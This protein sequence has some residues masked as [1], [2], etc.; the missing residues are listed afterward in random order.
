MLNGKVDW[1][2]PS[3]A[4][5]P[6]A[7]RARQKTRDRALL[8]RVEGA[9]ADGSLASIGELESMVR[10]LIAYEEA[11][12]SEVGAKLTTVVGFLA[13][14]VSMAL[15]ILAISHA[16]LAGRFHGSQR[17]AATIAAVI[18]FYVEL[19]LV[20]ACRAALRGLERR[21]YLC[22][23]LDDAAPRFGES[24][25]DLLR[26]RT[27]TRANVLLDMGPI[28]NRKVSHMS[29]SHAAVR[30]AL[31]GFLAMVAALCWLLIVRVLEVD[32]KHD[33][34]SIAT[35]VRAPAQSTGLRHADHA[36]FVASDSVAGG[37]IAQDSD[38]SRTP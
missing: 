33:P 24:D 37:G 3:L 15:A 16:D 5:M 7:T 2:W 13:I 26:R 9:V 36:H 28:V 35:D 20:A 18:G 12:G 25:L 11:R 4:P 14:A 10:E 30:N 31:W 29:V 21:G 19:Q 6:D 8:A 32:D 34:D 22:L 38:S 17:A 1:L 27:V 23:N